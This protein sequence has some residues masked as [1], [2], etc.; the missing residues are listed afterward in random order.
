MDL[1]F[2]YNKLI[3]FFF[4]IAT[5][6]SVY[7]A[8]H[9]KFEHQLE[10]FFPSHD[11]DIHFLTEFKNEVEADDN[12]LLI[13]IEHEKSVF[14]KTF[15]KKVDSLTGY[16]KDLPYII[17]AF[18][19]TNL[20]DFIKTPFGFVRIPLI[21][22]DDETKYHD[23]SIKI[24]RD[25][26]W[27]GRFIS[28]DSKIL[29]IALKTQDYFVQDEAWEL[30]REL[31]AVLTIF[32]EDDTH[33]VGKINTQTVFIRM[34]EDELKT[35][36]TLSIA[37]VI[38][39]L[40]IVFQSWRGVI[41]PLISVIVGMVI[42]F[43][44]LGALNQPL[45]LMS[46]LYP[47]LMLI[48]GM[49]DVI[50]IMI[51]YIEENESGKTRKEAMRITIR[52]IG[53]ATLF[54]SLT[55]AIGFMALITSVI[56]PI[57]RFGLTAALGVIVAYVVVILFT[58]S[59]LVNFNANQ[60][61]SAKLKF[62][63]WNRIFAYITRSTRYYPGRIM[64]IFACLFIICLYGISTVSTNTYLLSD[65][66]KDHKL[67]KD[68][69]FVD[70]KLSGAR[71]YEMAILA[72][73]EY[74][75][76]DLE[77]L[78][79]SEKVEM[80]LSDSMGIHNLFSPTTIY[81]SINKAS[82][83]GGWNKYVLPL[84][85]T[86]LDSYD[87]FLKESPQSVL[88]TVMNEEKT[89]GRISGRMQDLGSDKV[90]EINRR[91]DYWIRTNIDSTIAKFRITGT[92]LV[93]DANHKYVT[94]GLF[95]GLS[96]AFL[97]IAILMGIIFKNYKMILISLVPNIFPLLV[98]G[99]IMGL[100]GIELKASTAII[101]TIS[102]GIAVDD[103]IHFLSRFR[104]LQLKGFSTHESVRITLEETGKAIIITTIILSIGFLTLLFSDFYGTFYIGLLTSATLLSALFA[105]LFL[106]PVLLMWVFKEN[107]TM[108]IE[109][110]VNLKDLPEEEH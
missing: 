87:Q 9:L 110:D 25:P 67:R 104:L 63:S 69:V 58:T 43:G 84:S 82:E 88:K 70:E 38:L 31:N 1:L 50:H 65:I 14:N 44:I 45:D 3:I 94:R 91:I 72:Q 52:E 24:L 74:R 49:S 5:G 93:I 90:S 35:H 2:R 81:K 17:E 47:T 75:I 95:S 106:A 101:F 109:N 30:D 92:A 27:T 100:A 61:K 36:V 55:T 59:L 28:T 68:F 12:F 89:M 22:V 41:I 78:I 86:T 42:F 103:T 48:V 6:F 34:I 96:L 40:A 7:F 97:I 4:L 79:E 73:E 60:L 46:S 56:H 20:Y 37:L 13:A 105:D 16:C 11:E 64:L 62:G 32:P 23:D 54:T 53:L 29:I 26:R 85:Q 19:I 83:G 18:S 99:T 15:L 21:H 51:K 107:G 39:I 80:F 108:P 71:P 33:I 102:F 66:P 98:C 77:V 10:R 76:N 57:W 8:S